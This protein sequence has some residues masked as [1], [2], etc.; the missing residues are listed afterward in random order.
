[1]D[2]TGYQVPAGHRLR[3]AVSSA[4]FPLLWPAH[5]KTKLTLDL[6]SSCLTIP[7]HDR[8]ETLVRDLGQGY[9][10]PVNKT[11]KIRPFA[12]GFQNCQTQSWPLEA[13]Q[14][15]FWEVLGGQDASKM[16]S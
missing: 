11:K 10:C 14:I 6:A 8:S 16:P 1:M 12:T 2:D 13:S 3:L 5:K 15:P 7:F 4:Y 9:V